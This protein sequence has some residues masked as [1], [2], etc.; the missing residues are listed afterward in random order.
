MTVHK[1]ISSTT[2]YAERV[3]SA[4]KVMCHQENSTT[5][6]ADGNLGTQGWYEWWKLEVTEMQP[7]LLSHF[8][9]C[10]SLLQRFPAPSPLLR[11]ISSL[12]H[13]YWLELFTIPVGCYSSLSWTTWVVSIC[14]KDHTQAFSELTKY[15]HSNTTSFPCFI[16]SYQTFLLS[17][18]VFTWYG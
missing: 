12:L 2:L 11:S 1:A 18:Y 17:R 16:S 7:T 4:Q 10:H 15:C 3:F 14:P 5:G 8:H 6:E 9:Y 13:S